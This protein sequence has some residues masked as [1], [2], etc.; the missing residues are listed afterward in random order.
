MLSN[1]LCFPIFSLGNSWTTKVQCLALWPGVVT[2]HVDY[3]WD[4]WCQ[5]NLFKKT[6]PNQCNP[7]KEHLTVKCIKCVLWSS[8]YKNEMHYTGCS[9]LFIPQKKQHICYNFTW[10]LRL[11]LL[12]SNFERQKPLSLTSPLKFGHILRCNSATLWEGWT[13]LVL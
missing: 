12:K 2:W 8:E 5:A 1:G 3:R 11:G 13:P 7:L 4:S 6:Q 10:R 9:L